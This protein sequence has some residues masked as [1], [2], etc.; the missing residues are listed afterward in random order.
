MVVYSGQQLT[1]PE[2][3]Q[4]RLG[5]TQF[6]TKARVAPQDVEDLVLSM[7]RHLRTSTPQAPSL[8]SQTA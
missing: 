3:Q 1:E 4:L 2:M 7:V 6:L 5:P 8:H